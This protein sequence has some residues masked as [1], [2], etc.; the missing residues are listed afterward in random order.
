MEALNF[1]TLKGWGDGTLVHG[2]LLCT[3]RHIRCNH[4]R[5]Q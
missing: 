5:G 2:A 3:L 1:T 4:W